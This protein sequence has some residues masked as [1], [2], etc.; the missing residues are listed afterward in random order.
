MYKTNSELNA[1]V[2]ERFNRTLKEKMFKYFTQNKTKKYI[3][4][5]NDLVSSY[6]KSNHRTIK[7]SPINVNKKNEFK[8]W[9]SIYKLDRDEKIKFKF[10]EGD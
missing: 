6:N 5:I 8:I 7:T 9:K 4:I 1:A 3:S 2:V 10:N